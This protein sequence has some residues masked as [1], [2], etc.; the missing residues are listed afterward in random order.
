MR[1][2]VLLI[3]VDEKYQIKC[4][5]DNLYQPF[6]SL[7]E[8]FSYIN[9]PNKYLFHLFIHSFDFNFKDNKKILQ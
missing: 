6:C 9:F 4:F 5:L 3:E 2:L 8:F 1:F 7:I